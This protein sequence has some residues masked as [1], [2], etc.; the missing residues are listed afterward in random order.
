MAAGP[1]IYAFGNRPAPPPAAAVQDENW[2]PLPIGSHPLLVGV[3]VFYP[4][5][6]IHEL[7]PDPG[8]LKMCPQPLVWVKEMCP[9]R[10]KS[11]HMYPSMPCSG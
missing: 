9:F 7:G 2:C 6:V 10:H 1:S 3:S 5:A 4:C 11:G 8:G